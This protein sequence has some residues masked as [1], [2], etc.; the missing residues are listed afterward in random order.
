MKISEF[1]DTLKN[2]NKLLYYFGWLN[3][4]AFVVCLLLYFVDDTIV[5]GINA[6]VKPMKFTLSI[7]I[8]S[9]TFSWALHYLKNKVMASIVSWF[10]VI[11]MLVENV[12]IIIQAAR[13]EISHYNISSALNGMLFGL[14][15]VFIGINTFINAFTLLLF[16]IKS[17]V[18][19]SGYQLL[20]WRSGLLL[21]LIGSISGGLMIA[22]M[23]HTFGTVDGG[24]G[25]PFTNWSTQAGDMRAAH[26]FTI[27]GLQLIPLF[28]YVLPEHKRRKT[29]FVLLFSV[30]YALVCMLMHYLALQGKP[31][32]SF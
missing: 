20:A 2:R 23:G 9:W 8:Y 16:L 12:I 15:G 18:T 24:P 32:L 6:W 31:L 7:A 3:F 4:V 14:M 25:I 22:N 5:T 28:A 19:I 13:G 17:Q 26:F 1:L 11:T 27:H 10:V 29:L 30:G 21:F